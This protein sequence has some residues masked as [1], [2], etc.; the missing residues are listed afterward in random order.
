[1]LVL[2]RKKH[3]WVNIGADITV[4][5]VAVEGNKVRLGISA[6]KD[7]AVHRHEVARAISRERDNGSGTFD[8][9]TGETHPS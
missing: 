6:P 4:M 2:T 1:M 3:E 9:G 5:V 7:V 8:T